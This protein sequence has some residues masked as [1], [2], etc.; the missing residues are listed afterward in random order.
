MTLVLVRPRYFLPILTTARLLQPCSSMSHTTPITSSDLLPLS[1]L[2]PYEAPS[3]A[4]G[5]PHPPPSRLRL[6]SHPTPVHPFPASPS[7]PFHLLVKRDDQTGG[8]ETGGNK[9]RKLDFLLADALRRDSD[10]VVRFSPRA[11]QHV[12]TTDLSSLDTL[13]NYFGAR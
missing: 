1:A 7:L 11:L 12:F 3:F 2:H 8:P 9:I 6:S 4:R 13:L 5:L 10:T